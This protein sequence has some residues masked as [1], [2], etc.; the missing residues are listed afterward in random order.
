MTTG[1][2]PAEIVSFWREAGHDKWFAQDDDFDQAIRSRF[3]PAHEAVANG[4]LADWQDSAE[5]ALALVLLFDQFPRNMFRGTAR[6]FAT[7]PLARAVADRALA[8]GFD[9]ATEPALR[10]FFYLPFM[11][12]EAP[13]DHDR[14]MRLYEA[15][16]NAEQLRYAIEH[17]A[18]IQTFGRFPHRNRALGR[19]TTAAEQAFLEAAGVGQSASTSWPTS[20]RP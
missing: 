19:E 3:L 9:Q 12:S 7:D 13:I 4:E 5:G 2:A 8:R 11:H 10:Q 17:R 14:S 16:G 1:A 20:R 18:V 6:A 15:L